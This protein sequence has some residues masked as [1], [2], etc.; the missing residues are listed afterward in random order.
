MRALF[1]GALLCGALLAGVSSENQGRD[2]DT[3]RVRSQDTERMSQREAKDSFKKKAEKLSD[4]DKTIVPLLADGESFTPNEL[5]SAGQK[6][7]LTKAYSEL[8]GISEKESKEKIKD[9][10]SKASK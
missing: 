2:R 1:S 8:K 3:G 9:V 4:S 10:K 6:K 7:G 5:R